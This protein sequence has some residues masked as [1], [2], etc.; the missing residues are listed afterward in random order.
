MRRALTVLLAGSL[1]LLPNAVHATVLVA[2]DLTGLARNA[3][4]IVRGRVAQVTPQ[5]TDGRRR[6]VSVVSIDAIEYLKGDFGSRFEI[7]VPGGTMGRYSSVMAGAPSFKEG[8]ELILFL[9]A[10]PPSLPYIV[11]FSQGVYRVMADPASGR[12]VVTPP[13]LIAGA[14][15]QKITPGYP[16]RKLLALSY[17]TSQVK[18]LVAAAGP[19]GKTNGATPKATPRGK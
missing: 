14:T 12:Q 1:L 5:W 10:Q 3:Q 17:F 11:G 18:R 7:Q 4:V 19:A 9:A 6:I 2:T 8:Q 15:A 13:P 16:N